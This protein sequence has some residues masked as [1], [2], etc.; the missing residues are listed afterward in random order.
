MKLLIVNYEYPPLGG[1]GGVATEE[2]ATELA[3]GHRVHILT[4]WHPG[5]LRKEVTAGVLIHRVPVIPRRN[6]PTAT[7]LSML[8][9]VIIGFFSCW[10]LARKNKYDTINAQF[11]IPSGLAAAPAAWLTKTSF[12]LSFIGGDIYDPSKKSSPHRHA[13]LRW[14]V[15]NVAK[16]AAHLTAISSDTAERARKLHGVQGDIE[17]TRLGINPA[18]AAAVSRQELGLPEN[19]K[20]AVTVARLIP[21]KSY[22]VLLKAVSQVPD[23]HLAIIGTGPLQEKLIQLAAELNIANRVHFL[24]FLPA[25]RKAQVLQASDLFVS[26]SSHEG[27]GL[28]FLEAM[29]AGIP[30]VA[31]NEGGQTDFLHDG[32]NALL[33]SPNDPT[34]LANQIAKLLQDNL[35]QERFIDYNSNYVKQYYWKNIARQFEETLKKSYANRD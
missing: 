24:G 3:K 10:H 35:M 12:V 15:R 21:R 25:Q 5:L 14:L 20:L 34:A 6:L 16:Q 17:V 22:D 1:G 8:S 29:D 9:F 23:L 4:S 33:V 27:F 11:V 32:E 7:F 26:A 31:T 2:L 13:F 30:I 28:V 19:T 18:R